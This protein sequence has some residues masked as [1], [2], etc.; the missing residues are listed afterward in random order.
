MTLPTLRDAKAIYLDLPAT[1]PV[2]PRVLAAMRPF[3]EEQFGNPH[4]DHAHGLAPAEAIDTAAELVGGLLNADAGEIVFT[5]GATE[6][7]NAAIKGVMRAPD[8]RGNHIVI[9]AIEHKCV[10]EAARSLRAAGYEVTEVAPDAGG[11]IRVEAV[12]DALRPETALVS[13]MLLNNEVGTLQPV[14]EVAEIVRNHGAVMHS[15]AAQAVGKLEIDVLDLGVDLLSLSGHKFYGPKGIGALYLSSACPVRLEPLIHGGGQQAGRR[16]GTV[17][18]F[19]CAGLGEAARIAGEEMHEATKAIV[20]SAAAF[21][22]TLRAALP[23][24]ILNGN[25][26]MVTP[27]CRSYRFSGTDAAAVLQHLYG[28][29]SASLASACSSGSIKSSHVLTAMGLTGAQADA[30]IRFGFGRMTQEEEACLAASLVAEAV[31]HVR[32]GGF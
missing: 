1:T 14:A 27:F 30:S 7:N 32:R 29:L 18:A 10:L 28:R 15:D 17:P 6:A 4:S 19:L 26:E 20:T 25:P 23:D 11:I 8:R 22:A 16:G 24:A 31:D 9:S 5:S 3:L 2:D 13:L 21:D 12:A